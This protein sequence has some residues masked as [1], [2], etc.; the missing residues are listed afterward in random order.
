MLRID[1]AQMWNQRSRL[2]GLAGVVAT[3]QQRHEVS[4]LNCYN[5]H[6]QEKLSNSVHIS[7]NKKFGWLLVAI[8]GIAFAYFQQKNCAALAIFSLSAAIFLALVAINIPTALAPLNRAWFDL[9]LSLGKVISP[10]LL[11]I[12]FFTLIVPI[13]VMTRLFGRDVLMLKRREVFTYWINKESI[14]PES[15]KKQF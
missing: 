6:M 15:F 10:I 11:S 14:H 12:I 7:S 5:N 1:L 4:L 2:N 3:R 8:F 13:A 9:S